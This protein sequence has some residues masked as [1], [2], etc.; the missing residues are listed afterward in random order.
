MAT[1]DLGTVV[2]EVR[3]A[4]DKLKADLASSKR[5]VDN[6]TSKK[7]E[8]AIKADG[9]KA[10]AESR[11]VAKALTDIKDRNVHVKANTS[12]AD[13]GLQRVAKNAVGADEGFKRAN[14]GASILSGGLGVATK[15][16]GGLGVAMIAKN[17]V[18]DA[19]EGLTRTAAATGQLESGLQSTKNAAN[20]TVA[21]MS[22]YAG[23]LERV[24]GTQAEVTMEGQALLQTFTK[25]RNEAGLG[26]DIFNRAT[27]AA[28]NLSRKGFGDVA[29]SAKMLGKALNDPIKGI[30]AMSRAGVTFSE[31]QKTM[32]A[33]LVETGDMLGA[34]KIILDEVET[35][36]GG[37]AEAYGQ[38]LPGKVERANHAIGEISE[39]LMASAAPSL[40]AVAGWV[41]DL[42]TKLNL[43]DS[44]DIKL[45][46]EILEAG[47]VAKA[48]SVDLEL[49]FST[50][51]RGNDRMNNLQTL[52]TE[53]F[54]G[55]AAGRA[56]I[57]ELDYALQQL[58]SS[59]NADFANE[60]FQAIAAAAKA[61]GVDMY[62]F[63]SRFPQY[64]AAWDEYQNSLVGIP[65]AEQEAG[66]A[67]K[68]ITTEFDALKESVDE[69]N[70]QMDALFG[71]FVAA[72]QA[73]ADSREAIREVR[74]ELDQLIQSQ[75][76]GQAATDGLGNI[77]RDA[78]GTFENEATALGL[79]GNST[80][81]VARRSAFL[82]DR[83]M[84]LRNQ[85][86]ELRG[87]IDGYIARLNAI[88]GS[89]DTRVNVNVEEGLR[90]LQRL[91]SALAS[92][93]QS[94]TGQMSWSGWRGFAAGGRPPLD[95]PSWV[96][97]RG[98][99][100]WVPDVPGTIH[101]NHDP[102]TRAALSGG[103]SLATG[104]GS[105]DVYVTVEGSVIG[106]RDLARQIK[107]IN[108]G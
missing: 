106:M 51:Q 66:A 74:E 20:T 105:G 38:T 33:S 30:S 24:T 108:G 97:E 101:A 79:V 15:M 64:N 25:V 6:A 95:E 46:E 28:I 35:Q 61:S 57:S 13:V 43:L 48:A 88:P 73:S 5:L 65:Q 99:E 29:G 18:A 84:E 62:E 45:P 54:S 90:N 42:S 19:W 10:V 52:F 85:Y 7:P 100:L 59:G 11:R 27:E 23:A 104:R 2:V 22:A 58:V 12:G 93:A 69:T 49:L 103:S 83:L 89:K 1:E 67:I 82:R 36:V 75:L 94:R 60:Q 92:A 9:T 63:H 53:G 4:L 68:E 71:R 34:Q 70:V 40:E 78:I 47:S 96:G 32:I 102:L 72:D 86:P 3:A 80:D 21:G 26:N 14:R 37:A 8:I 41:L 98:P 17:L 76:T 44:V 55:L 87:Q 77:V 107:E 81:D 39:T 31:G 50:V 56:E 91:S 16:A